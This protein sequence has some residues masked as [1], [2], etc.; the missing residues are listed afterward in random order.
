MKREELDKKKRAINQPVKEKIPLLEEQTLFNKENIEEINKALKTEVVS[1]TIEKLK[2]N[3][4]LN[5]WVKEGLDL[6]NQSNKG[7]CHFCEQPMP[8]KQD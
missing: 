1:E 3:K 4:T 7:D 8:E 5:K 2:N 6:Y